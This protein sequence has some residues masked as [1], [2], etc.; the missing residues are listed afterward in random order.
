M[1]AGTKE[2]PWVLVT[3]PGSSECHLQA[4]E[5]LHS[6][7]LEQKDWVPLGAVDENKPAA[8]GSV[9]A[10]GGIRRTRWRAGMDSARAIAA[11]SACIFRRCWRN[12]AWPNL[13]TKSA[14][15]PF[16]A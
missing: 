1:A 3:A 12:W 7:L 10:W 4:I 5:D 9:E 6:W 2:D 8:E 11:G 15:T 14:T 13:P 16:G